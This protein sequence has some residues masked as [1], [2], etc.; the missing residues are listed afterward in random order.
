MREKEQKLQGA[1]TQLGWVTVSLSLTQLQLK[2]SLLWE[3]G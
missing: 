1:L 3:Q 2:H